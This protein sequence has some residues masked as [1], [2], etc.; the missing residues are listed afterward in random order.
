MD[1]VVINNGLGNQM[2]QYAF[3]L[4]KKN[5]NSRCRFIFDPESHNEHNGSELD[6]IFGVN[7]GEGIIDKLLTKIIGYRNRPKIWRFLSLCGVRIVRESVS[8]DFDP[9]ML[10]KHRL[11]L[12]FFIGG[13]HSE[14]YFKEI[15]PQVL[16]VFRFPSISGAADFQEILS[17]VNK[18]ANSVSIHVRRGDFLTIE[19]NNPYQL[20]G[21]ATE[22]YYKKAISTI[23]EQVDDPL[24]FCFSNDIKWCQDFFKDENIVFVTCNA[25]KDSWRDMYLMSLCKHHINANS[26]FSWWGAWLAD[27]E[28]IIICP[29]R[30]LLNVETK[31]IY[32]E[33]WIK[34]DIK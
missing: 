5:E 15:R 31:D 3:Y 17:S 10:K 16:A 24:F 11:G 30:F 7:F 9:Q 2:S 4:A 8:Y 29:N 13:W 22:S 19:K 6:Q 20:G 14:K 33:S 28:G 23:K 18:A 21:V 25:G 1:I 12:N 32:P 34:I 26:T 27:K